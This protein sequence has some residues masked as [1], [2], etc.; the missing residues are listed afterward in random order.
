MS[1]RPLAA[2]FRQSLA[3]LIIIIQELN[4]F[5]SNVD[6]ILKPVLV[7]RALHPVNDVTSH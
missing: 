3:F 7:A 2:R 6:I 4:A 1:R 5:L